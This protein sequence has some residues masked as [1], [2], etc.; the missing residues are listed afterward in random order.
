[1][2]ILHKEAQHVFIGNRILDKILVQA[3]AED[4][5]GGMSVNG[6]FREDW[7][8]RET[9]YLGVVKELHYPF[10]AFPE[11]ASVA[12]IEYHYDAGV[13]YGLNLGTVPRLADCGVELLDSR[14]DYLGIAMQPFYQFV[15]IVRAVHCTRFKGF[16]F[17]LGLCVEVVTVNHKH[18]LIHVV[19]FGSK[20]CGLE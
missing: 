19:Q 10:V 4:F 7:R 18:H 6:I 16:I 8:T 20:L 5:F 11:V 2:V 14:N 1:M 9:E 13:A 3:V 15:R 17:R 12:L